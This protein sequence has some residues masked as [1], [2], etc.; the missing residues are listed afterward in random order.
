MVTSEIENTNRFF[1]SV[2]FEMKWEWW[3]QDS[4]FSVKEIICA[5]W[6]TCAR[7]GQI[8][9]KRERDSSKVLNRFVE[10]VL[11]ENWE[12]LCD[13]WLVSWSIEM[14]NMWNSKCKKRYT[15]QC[16]KDFNELFILIREER[17]GA[18]CSKWAIISV[19]QNYK[20]TN[21]TTG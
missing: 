5:P 12:C 18:V 7:R 3:M 14:V 16:G 10:S 17:V 21:T 15:F 20:W 13:C 6:H 11:W 1:F 2:G 8:E 4:S 9:R 19:K